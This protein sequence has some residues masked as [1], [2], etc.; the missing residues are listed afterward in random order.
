MLVELLLPLAASAVLPAAAAG[1]VT[2]MTI[3][4]SVLPPS[5]SSGL[6]CGSRTHGPPIL[7]LLLAAS[8][9]FHGQP[10]REEP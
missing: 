3:G 1:A 9:T 10:N 4:F 5:M 6:P 2:S 7:P 8:P